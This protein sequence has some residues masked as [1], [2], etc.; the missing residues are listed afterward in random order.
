MR[1]LTFLSRSYS[2][3]INYKRTPIDSMPDLPF[4]F[5]V[6]I[7]VPFV[8]NHRDTRYPYSLVRSVYLSFLLHSDVK[9]IGCET[10]VNVIKDSIPFLF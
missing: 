4:F 7:G 10:A 8:P 2:N 1:A 3:D 5:K 6:K 9:G